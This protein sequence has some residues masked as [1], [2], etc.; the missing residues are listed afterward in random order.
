MPGW[1][2]YVRTQNAT[3]RES[4]FNIHVKGTAHPLTNCPLCPKEI[5][6]LHGD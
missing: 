5:L 2:Q 1:A 4:C 3:I 6:C